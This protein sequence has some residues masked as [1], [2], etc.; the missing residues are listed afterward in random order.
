MEADVAE[1]CKAA[2]AAGPGPG[3]PMS[4]ILERQQEEEVA[5]KLDL[6]AA[7]LPST[8]HVVD[9][10]AAPEGTGYE[11]LLQVPI[12][13]SAVMHFESSALQCNRLCRS[14]SN[15]SYAAIHFECCVRLRCTA[16][17]ASVTKGCC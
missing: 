10:G 6:S 1:L 4:Q 15:A 17:G 16:S 9:E 11:I 3:T 14:F 5:P 13:V 2:W 7:P 12:F 8:E